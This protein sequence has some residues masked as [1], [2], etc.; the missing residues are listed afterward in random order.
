MKSPATLR[1]YDPTLSTHYVADS[2]EVGIQASIY[3]EV[4][5]G[6]WIPIDHISR[7][8]RGT[9]QSMQ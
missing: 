6:T 5:Q 3:Q 4:D 9:E 2:P 7:A 1:A 8:F